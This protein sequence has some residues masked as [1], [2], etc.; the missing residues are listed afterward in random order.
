MFQPS[1]ARTG[2]SWARPRNLAITLVLVLVAAALG[3]LNLQRYG[4]Q[5]YR[6]ALGTDE[7]GLSAY[8]L[9]TAASRVVITHQAMQARPDDP[10]A[11]VDAASARIVLAIMILV[12][13]FTH[14]GIPGPPLPTS[15]RGLG[16]MTQPL[17]LRQC[18]SSTGRYLWVRPLR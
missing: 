5:Q 7:L 18:P 4:E 6:L 8:D 1:A 2:P 17:Q 11:R 12:D 9:S 3:L 16:H 10:A 14:P 15:R 13:E